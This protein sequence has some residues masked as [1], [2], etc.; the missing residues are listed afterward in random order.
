MV[1]K[2]ID[3]DDGAPYTF[4]EL[5]IYYKGKYKKNAIQ[6]YW[7]KSCT[8]VKSKRQRKRGKNDGKKDSQVN[9]E[10]IK[11]TKGNS[12]SRS[13]KPNI[14]LWTGSWEVHERENWGAYLTVLGIPAE[15]HEVAT[16]A[17]DFHK[18]RVE[19]SRFTMDHQIPAQKLHLHFVADLDGEWHDS[20]YPKPTVGH[21]VSA[22]NAEQQSM[23]RWKNT[24]I[25]EPLCW[26]TEIPNFLGMDGRTVTIERRLLSK[27][28]IKMTVHVYQESSLEAGPCFTTMKKTSTSGP[29]PITWLRSNDKSLATAAARHEAIEQVI[30]M[31]SENGPEID[32]AQL[33]DRVMPSKFEGTARMVIGASKFYQT[34]IPEWMKPEVLQDTTPAPL[35]GGVD[36]EWTVQNEPKGVGIVVVPWNAPFTLALIPLIG[37]LAA[38]NKVAIKPADL[39]PTVSSVLR[40]LCHKYLPGLV[41]VEEGGKEAV[42][43]LIDEGADHCVFTGGGEIAKIVAA[44]CA[45]MLTPVTLE[46]GGK[47][48][49]FIDCSLQ[50]KMLECAVQEILETKIGKT[51]QFCCAHDY[52]LVHESIYDKFCTT[53][54]KAVEN[55]GEKRNVKMIGRRQYDVVKRKLLGSEAET[56]PP[57]EGQF[58][59]NDDDMTLPFTGLLGPPLDNV[60]LTQEIFGPVLPILKVTG[61][62]QAISIVNAPQRMKPLIAYCYSEDDASIN[63]FQCSTSSG[64]LAINAGPQRALG[65]FHVGFGGI[66]PSGTG[67]SMWGKEA[68]R[69]FSNRK[70]VLRA[71]GG[72]G[73]SAFMA[74]H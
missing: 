13:R 30:K 37:M 62:D 28:E 17:P 68:L 7:D 16:K 67:H 41:W 32:A 29:T 38:G 10:T 48:P 65:N 23:P 49:V 56:V 5:R 63:A 25:E 33:K 4:E 27:S 58:T 2:R 9:A 6:T 22:A 46:L 26:K 45:K 35:K 66:G 70:V 1:E 64:N 59:P 21:Y 69:E 12:A 40:R 71:K 31:V 52:A 51:G 15:N 44:R 3:P 50:D 53:F 55:V 72:F 74:Q 42:E 47:S 36:A 24:W 18:Y 8:P 73:Q 39:V 60:L 19:K 14:K 61:V 11:S 20:P 54:K 34:L 43:R 57:M